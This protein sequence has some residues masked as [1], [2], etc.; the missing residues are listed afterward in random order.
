VKPEWLEDELLLAAGSDGRVLSVALILLADDYGNG[1]A[2][3]MWLAAQVFAMEPQPQEKL[4]DAMEKL[5][6]WFCELYRVRG[7]MYYHVCGWKKHQ[8]VDK[9][10][11]PHV[12]GISEADPVES[13]EAPDNLP[14]IPAPDHD[15]DHDRYP[16][17]EGDH[18]HDPAR[19]G[20]GSG[21]RYEDL[22]IGYQ[23]RF[24]ST[25]P[26]GMTASES[27]K[28]GEHLSLLSKWSLDNELSDEQCGTM[29][30]NFFD[31]LAV[32]E[33]GFW[34]AWL[35]QRPAD[36]LRGVPLKPRGSDDV[37][38]SPTFEEV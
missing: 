14:V 26:S 18:D 8:R 16:D 13:R 27:A 17:P 37:P 29:L 15:H 11:K 38:D 10:G 21:S 7:Q 35:S 30:D 31:D 36:F 2:N 33:K 22:R 12:P 25:D 19:G 20:R 32:V 34:I 4:R 5:R 1:R 9:P 28:F 24:A 23:R 3:E 6:G